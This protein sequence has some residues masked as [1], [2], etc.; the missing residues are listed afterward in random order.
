MVS[1]AEIFG[2][3]CL[4]IVLTGMGDDGSIGI[5]KIR[6][7]GGQ[8]IAQS[9]ESSVVFGMP[10]KAIKTGAIQ[11]ILDLDSILENVIQFASIFALKSETEQYK[12][13]SILVIDNKKWANK[14]LIDS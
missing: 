3:R 2:P 5:K 4:G 13:W 1:A 11:E 9:E 8:T 12:D 14:D 7:L 10:S 6:E